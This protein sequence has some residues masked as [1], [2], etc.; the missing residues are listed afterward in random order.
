LWVPGGETAREEKGGS[1]NC[2][3]G[4]KA[5][6]HLGELAGK[7]VVQPGKSLRSLTKASERGY[8]P[9]RKSGR[10]H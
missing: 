1:G 10:G 2:P 4:G 6:D 8:F 7:I 9:R 5:L 3:S